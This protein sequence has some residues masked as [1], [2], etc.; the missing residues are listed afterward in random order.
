VGALGAVSQAHSPS[1]AF[2]RA[3]QQ[4]IGHFSGAASPPIQVIAI[5][6]ASRTMIVIIERSAVMGLSFYTAN[7]GEA[8]SKCSSGENKSRAGRHPEAALEAHSS[9]FVGFAV[10]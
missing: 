3:A 6:C 10:N 7:T 2:A 4:L 5:A 8:V 9:L 1:P